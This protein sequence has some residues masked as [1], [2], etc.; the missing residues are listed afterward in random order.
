MLWC[1]VSL[2]QLTQERPETLIRLTVDPMLAPQPALRYL[3]LPELREL[4]PGNPIANYLKCLLDQDFT[5]PDSTLGRNALKQA[6]RA[7]RMDKPDWQI[8]PKLKTDG[9]S[10]LLPDLQKMREL[11]GGLLERFR[12]EATARRFDDAIVSAKTLFALARHTGEH[13][14]LIGD[15]VG[16]AIAQIAISPLE[17]MLQQPGCPNLYWA[18]TNLPSPFISLEKGLEG[19]RMMIL[20]ELRDLDDKTPMTPAHQEVEHIHRPAARIR[21]GQKPPEGREVDRGTNPR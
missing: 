15:L 10:L 7:A 11:A 12:Q 3:L 16:L 21:G 19:E 1:A 5:R 6:E 14:T 17:E 9:I 20:T 13:P 2:P 18:L 8:L 4:T